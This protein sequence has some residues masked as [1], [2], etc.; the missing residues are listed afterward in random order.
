MG[1]WRPKIDRLIIFG[2]SQLRRSYQ[3]D[4]DPR[5]M[6]VFYT[7]NYTHPCFMSQF[8]HVMLKIFKCT[9]SSIQDP[10]PK[11][12]HRNLIPTGCTLNAHSESDTI[13]HKIKKESHWLSLHHLHLHHCPSPP[14]HQILHCHHHQ[15]PPQYF[16]P[17]PPPHNQ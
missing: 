14:C 9:H 3:G 6:D 8:H 11:M 10:I 16:H 7:V 5:S 1:P 15:L 13:K 17:P 2:P 12:I 4:G